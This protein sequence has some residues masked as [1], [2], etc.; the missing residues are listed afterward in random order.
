MTNPGYVTTRQV[1][2]MIERIRGR[3]E[4]HFWA[5][6]EEFYRCGTKAPRS[7]CVLDVSKLLATGVPMRPVEEAL[8]DALRNWCAKEVIE[9]IAACG[10]PTG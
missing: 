8:E 7:N 2:G 5:N 4:F 9:P 1:I 6:D 10:R 3:R